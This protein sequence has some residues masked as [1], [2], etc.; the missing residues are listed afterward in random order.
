MK[1]L[2]DKIFRVFKIKSDF[3]IRSF[4]MVELVVVVVVAGIIIALILPNFSK[5]L[6][7]ARD[8]EAVNNL[9]LVQAAQKVY[10]MEAGFYFPRDESFTE[11]FEGINNFLNLRLSDK[12]WNYTLLCAD[13]SSGVCTEYNITAQR[14]LGSF[15]RNWSA[16]A[17]VEPS[18]PDCP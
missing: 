9:K 7:R 13:N 6:E 17:S 4:T 14:L 8:K 1:K 2:L 5:A 15:P 11:Y 18:C 16:N 12:F 10:R 3:S